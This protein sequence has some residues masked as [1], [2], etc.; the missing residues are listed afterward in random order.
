MTDKLYAIVYPDIFH[1]RE[2]HTSIDPELH[3]GLV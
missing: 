1:Y 3:S 2:S